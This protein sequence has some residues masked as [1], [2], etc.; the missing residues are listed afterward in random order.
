MIRHLT[1]PDRMPPVNGYSHVTLATGTVVHVS[2]QVPVRPDGSVVEGDVAAQTEQVFLN[3]ETALRA[4]GAT[5]SDVV[6]MSY[7]LVD[8]ADLP[9]VRGVRDRFLD[10]DGLPASSLV[11][12]AGLVN[13][14]FRVEIDAVAVV[15]P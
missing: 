14:A 2:G 4:A 12:V 11:Q 1:R 7:F 5:W 9:Q 3:L 8:I 10:P 13:P 15:Q 6:K